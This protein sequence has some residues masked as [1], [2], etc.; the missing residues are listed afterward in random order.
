VSREG[1]KIMKKERAS[2]VSLLEELGFVLEK[3]VIETCRRLSTLENGR[4][5][6]R[7][8]RTR[9]RSLEEEENEV[10]SERVLP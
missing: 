1:S 10:M 3:L 8:R 9:R 6:R 4:R 7:R 2:S 5:R